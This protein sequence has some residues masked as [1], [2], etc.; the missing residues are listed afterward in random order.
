MR[1]LLATVP[2]SGQN[3]NYIDTQG[4]PIVGITYHNVDVLDGTPAL[5]FQ[6][7]ANNQDKENPSATWIDVLELSPGVATDADDAG[8]LTPDTERTALG[9]PN[10]LLEGTG[11]LTNDF[12]LRSIDDIPQY[13]GA[14]ASALGEDPGAAFAEAATQEMANQISRLSNTKRPFRLPNILRIAL[15]ANQTTA[16]VQFW[17]ALGEPKKLVFNDQIRKVQVSF[18]NGD[19]DSTYFELFPG[20]RLVGIELPAAFTTTD[21]TFQTPKPNGLY[22]TL[23]P[24]V[25]T[26]ANWLN[27]KEW[28]NEQTILTGALPGDIFKWPS[29]AQGKY[30]AVPDLPYLELPRYLRLHGSGNQ[31][32]A[33]TVTLYIQ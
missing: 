24:A 28:V 21:L 20:E 33:R 26:D 22:S 18:A 3:S 4:L 9:I 15:G 23:D 8:S 16:A 6:T 29:A 17:V 5:K 27:V 7:P 30:L 19:A 32:A 13:F 10:L 1:F 25:I 2:Q 14:A 11:A 31:G 12:F